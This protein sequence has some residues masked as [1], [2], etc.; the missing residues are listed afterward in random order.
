MIIRLSEIEESFIAR[1]SMEVSRF[2]EVEDGSTRVITPVTYELTIRKFDNLVTVQGPVGCTMSITCSRC[3]DDFTLGLKVFLDIKLTPRTKT[4]RV[5]EVELKRDDMD[6]YYY[7]GD[8]IDLD[9][10]I[11]E[12]VLLNVPTRPVCTEDCKGLCPV[13]GKSKNVE[14]CQCDTTTH[15]L[16]GEKLKSFLN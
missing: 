16:L 10:F 5:S 13:C 12:E 3:L 15:T 7:E 8:E 11:Y 1:G 14:D 2:T 4:P 9:P 6:V